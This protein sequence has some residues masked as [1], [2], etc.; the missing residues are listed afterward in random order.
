MVFLHTSRWTLGYSCKRGH[1]CLSLH[2]VQ[3]I[4][5]TSV[6]PHFILYNLSSQRWTNPSLISDM[7]ERVK[8]SGF[9]SLYSVYS[10]Q[11]KY[12]YYDKYISDEL[13][14]F[15]MYSLLQHP[16]SY[17]NDGHRTAYF[18]YSWCPNSTDYS[19]AN[20]ILS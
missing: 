18:P 16:L 19:N 10:L 6:T 11:A 13:K 7:Y 20:T 15:E 4:F 9:L 17:V 1:R 8:L 2:R 12:E 5:T 14:W 3:P